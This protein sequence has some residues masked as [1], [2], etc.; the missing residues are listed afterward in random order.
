MMPSL[1]FNPSLISFSSTTHLHPCRPPPSLGRSSRIHCSYS[2]SQAPLQS[3]SRFVFFPT[4]SSSISRNLVSHRTY[5]RQKI[6][7]HLQQYHNHR[8]KY[9]QGRWT[10]QR[11]SMILSAHTRMHN[12][13]TNGFILLDT[14]ITSISPSLFLLF[15][16]QP[17]WSVFMRNVNPSQLVRGI[18]GHRELL[19][20][21]LAWNGTLYITS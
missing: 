6:V 10:G 7:Q 3:L 4:S 16:R 13:T 11:S 19:L 17:V 9:H 8:Y 2:P 15:R 5:R 21:Y 1:N 14:S 18:Q 12:H 20:Q